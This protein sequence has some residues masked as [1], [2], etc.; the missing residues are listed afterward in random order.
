AAFSAD[1]VV[2]DSGLAFG[3]NTAA[4]PVRGTAPQGED[5]EVRALSLD[6]GGAATTAWHP[7]G[8]AAPNGQWHAQLT[9]PRTASW[10]RIEARLSAS[11]AVTAQSATRFGVGHVIALWGADTLYSLIDPA[12]DLTSPPTLADDDAV[13]LIMAGAGGPVRHHLSAAA[14]HTA[15]AAAMANVLQALRPGEKFALICH[16]VPATSLTALVD[17]AQPVRP[18]SADLALHAAA[19][20]DGQTVGLAVLSWFED[21]T[22]LGTGFGEALLPLMAGVTVAGG[23]VI[24]PAEIELGTGGS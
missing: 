18:W 8:P 17:D 7:A 16:A 20:A 1:R 15:A 13:Q 24:F 2:F 21:M 6:D 22:T 4:V 14:P 5:V 3:R 23:T 9:V 19:T 10:M 11:P 12:A